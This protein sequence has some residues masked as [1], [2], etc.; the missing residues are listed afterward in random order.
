MND[1]L[2][3][4]RVKLF[5]TVHDSSFTGDGSTVVT[6]LLVAPPIFCCI[7]SRSLITTVIK[8]C[9]CEEAQRFV[10]IPGRISIQIVDLPEIISIFSLA[11]RLPN[12]IS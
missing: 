12:V 11:E 7:K 5:Y 9:V 4:L 8:T 6:G 10:F 3:P 2:P 1:F